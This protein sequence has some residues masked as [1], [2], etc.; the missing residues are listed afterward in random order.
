MSDCI[1]AKIT[2]DLV[3][4]L[5]GKI[6]TTTAGNRTIVAETQRTVFDSRGYDTYVEVGGPWPESLDSDAN[7]KNIVLHYV[8]EC[9]IS[10]LNDIYPNDPI[11]AQTKNAGADLSNLVLSDITR[12]GNALLTE[13]DAIPYYYFKEINDSVVFVIRM[14]VSVNLFVQTDDLYFNKN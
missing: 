4:A 2:D 5:N 10:G 6:L 13:V 8:V 11:T 14:D 7:E 9:Y 1:S 12:G 3:S